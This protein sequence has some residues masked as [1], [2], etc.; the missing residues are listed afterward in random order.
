MV[1]EEMERAFPTT[2][3]SM[4]FKVKRQGDHDDGKQIAAM[5]SFQLTDEFCER[6]FQQAGFKG[7][8]GVFKLYYEI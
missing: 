5:C 6:V 8:I 4:F 3:T 7:D 2:I 1:S